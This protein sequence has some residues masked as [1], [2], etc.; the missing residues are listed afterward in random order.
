MKTRMASNDFQEDRPDCAASPAV[1]L[2]RFPRTTCVR[3][4]WTY[5]EWRTRMHAIAIKDGFAAL[6][7]R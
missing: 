3:N 1:V 4:A 5:G 2:S 6:E 7:P